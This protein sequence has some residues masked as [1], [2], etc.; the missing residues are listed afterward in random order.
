MGCKNV[1]KDTELFD[2]I[3]EALA[4]KNILV[5]SARD[6]NYKT[7]GAS[8]GLAYN[9]KVGAESA[10]DINL[11][12][13]LNTVMCQSAHIRP[14]RIL[15]FCIASNTTM[16]HLLLAV[17]ASPVR[18]EPYIPT[19]FRWSGL[20]AP[21]I[22][23]P[24]N[25]SASVILTP[26]IGS[27]VGGDITAGAFAS[28]LWNREEYSL[29]IDLG[30]NGEIVFGNR[31]FMELC[32]QSLDAIAVFAQKGSRLAVSDAGCGAAIV[33]SALQ[34]ASLNVFINTKSLQDRALAGELNEKCLGM[35]DQYGR[36]ADEIFESV[37]AGFFK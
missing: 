23:L 4:G 12:K 6:E 3:A 36:L 29:F 15:R 33:K 9:Q 16:N 32:C 25:H 35:L 20:K 22:G 24:G 27:Y 37:K 2:K 26:N 28:L 19:F 34:A 8:A 11:A 14:K 30:T 31:D 13:Q 21:D 17:D 18:M 10:V 7:V 5:L 1:E